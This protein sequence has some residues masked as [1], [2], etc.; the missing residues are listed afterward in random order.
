MHIFQAIGLRIRRLDDSQDAIIIHLIHLSVS[1][2][3]KHV[4]F[5]ASQSEYWESLSR[6]LPSIFVLEVIRDIL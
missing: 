1:H 5:A 3:R 6:N 2:G 4:A